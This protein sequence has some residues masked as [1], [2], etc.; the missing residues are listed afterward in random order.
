MSAF[1]F[2]HVLISF[3]EYLLHLP[4][5]FQLSGI[6][7]LKHDLTCLSDPFWTPPVLKSYF[8]QQEL[9]TPNEY[10]PAQ[11]TKTICTIIHTVTI[12]FGVRGMAALVVNL[13]R[14]CIT[15]FLYKAEMIY[16][17]LFVFAL[18]RGLLKHPGQQH[19]STSCYYWVPLPFGVLAVSPFLRTIL[20]YQPPQPI[21]AW[22]VS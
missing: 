18:A 19:C 7:L 14:A 13:P 11:S 3:L 1:Q 17:A 2:V 20:F 12:W 10:T 9:L 8:F 22:Y 4:F 5:S 15:P 21:H 6:N 16:S